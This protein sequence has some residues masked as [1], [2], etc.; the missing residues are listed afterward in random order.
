MGKQFLLEQEVAEILR[1]SLPTVGRRI[2]DKEIPSVQVGRRR[3]IP[4]AF[5]EGLYQP[6]KAETQLEEVANVCE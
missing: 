6:Q 3:L 2:K 1:I 4:A 5:I